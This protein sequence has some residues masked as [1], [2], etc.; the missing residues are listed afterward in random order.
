MARQ[1]V[2]FTEI[3]NPLCRFLL[4]DGT[5]IA[6]KLVLMRVVRTDEK[7]PDGQ[8]RHEFQMQHVVDQVAPENEINMATLLKKGENK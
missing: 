8:F 1:Q 7:L 2:D 4:D 6:V 3:N 5:E